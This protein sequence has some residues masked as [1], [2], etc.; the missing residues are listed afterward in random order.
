MGEQDPG[1]GAT[2]DLLACLEVDTFRGGR[3]SR[4][5]VR[6]FWRQRP[7]EATVG[8]LPNEIAA[9]LSFE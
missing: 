7:A 4:L 9:D 3:R 1:R 6:H 8:L 2:I 5:R